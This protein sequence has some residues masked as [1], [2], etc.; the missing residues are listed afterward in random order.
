MHY[1]GEA[2]GSSYLPKMLGT[3]EK[4]LQDVVRQ[5]SSLDFRTVINIGAAEGYYAVGFTRLFPGAKVIAFE[6]DPHGQDLIRQLATENA[7]KE[8]VEILGR[9]NPSELRQLMPSQGLV[10]VLCDV[11]GYENEL[12]DP[13]GIPALAAAYLIIE[14]HDFLVPEVTEKLKRRFARTHT[15]TTIA[16]VPR[17]Y[18]D[19]AVQ[20]PVLLR[21]IAGPAARWC[22]SERRGP[23]IKWLVCEPR[24]TIPRA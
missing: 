14:T 10:L 9:C 20:L 12:L 16:A 21:L 19:L 15:I 4:E 2:I 22:L 24:L 7:V 3:Y 23:S 17:R 18:A 13:A 8:S 5:L 1:V 6:M 11:E